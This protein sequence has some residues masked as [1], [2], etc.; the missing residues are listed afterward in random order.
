MTDWRWIWP[1][2]GPTPVN[3]NTDSEMFDREDFPYSE[4][5][6]REAIQN[7]LDARL[8]KD[9]PAEIRFR[10]HE[11][12]TEAPA[13]VL[14]EAMNYRTKADLWTPE[15]WKNGGSRVDW[16]TIEDF[17]TTGLRGDLDD[18]QSDFWGYWLN[19]GITNK[20]MTGRGG[21]GIGRVTFLIASRIQTVI[22][23]TRRYEDGLSAVCGMAILK[24]MKTEDG[25]KSTHAFLA[26]KEDE[27]NDVF[28]LHNGDDAVSDVSAAFNFSG[29]ADGDYTSGFALAIPFPHKELTENGILASAIENFA[30]AILAQEIVVEAGDVKLDHKTIENIVGSCYKEFEADRIGSDPGRYIDLIKRGLET[31]ETKIEVDTGKSCP[32]APVRDSADAV[33]I[34]DILEEGQCVRFTI[35][36]ELVR[37]GE[38][39]PVC[40]RIVAGK[41]P[42]GMK[43]VDRFFREGMSLP[44]LKARDKGGLDVVIFVNP[45]ELAAY[46]NL[47]EGKAHLNLLESKEI[48]NRLDSSGYD[49]RYRAKRF[50]KS[51]PI[52]IRKFLERDIEEPTVDVFDDF[53]SIP[54]DDGRRGGG[55][56]N[57]NR[58][59][60]HR[61]H[62]P[63]PSPPIFKAKTLDDGF[64]LWANSGFD[65]WPVK[66]E[67]TMAYA[68]GT[69][70][71]KWSPFDFTPNGLCV[72]CEDCI[73]DF[74]GNVL[75]LDKCYGN[76]SISV[77]GF[78]PNRELDTRFNRVKSDA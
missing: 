77:T 40:L 72:K 19:F 10:F 61:P 60:S 70:T 66:L 71:P 14:R 3:Q 75:V 32:L 39:V 30:P 5:L 34:R 21:R 28:H 25:F 1:R 47:C 27:Q 36:F 23:M 54:A 56:P 42:D 53:F 45:G 58:T 64:R 46:L 33:A 78:D 35:A 44:D 67:V 74:T 73:I 18:R 76:F 12:E 38:P 59:P 22:G 9:R 17:N 29:Y 65:D 62:P 2:T 57:P 4:T 37:C 11:S 7:T 6:V 31:P 51:L 68:D 20:M 69:R 24:A 55:A 8:Y 13:S 43:P 26:E 41:T 50:V 52:E 15:I 49:P 16:I 63:P 48:S